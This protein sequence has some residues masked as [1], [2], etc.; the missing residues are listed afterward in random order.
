MSRTAFSER[1][2]KLVGEPPM[3]YVTSWRMTIATTK[4]KKSD[5][6][7]A[8]LANALGYQSEAAFSRAYKKHCGVS[9]GKIRGL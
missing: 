1:F 3:R 4:L 6:S 2:N 5:V 9:P 7:V 8:E